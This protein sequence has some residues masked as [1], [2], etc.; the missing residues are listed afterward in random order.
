MTMADVTELDATAVVH[1]LLAAAGRGLYDSWLAE[2]ERLSDI[3]CDLLFAV[4]DRPVPAMSEW[5]GAGT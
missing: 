5:T 1:E 3:G 4:R 2:F